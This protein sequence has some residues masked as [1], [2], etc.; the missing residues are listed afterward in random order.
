MGKYLALPFNGNVNNT[1]SL[2]L[3]VITNIFVKLAIA[4]NEYLLNKLFILFKFFLIKLD[5]LTLLFVGDDDTIN[6]STKVSENFSNF[7]GSISHT[8]PRLPENKQTESAPRT[9]ITRLNS[10]IN[11]EPPLSEKQANLESSVNFNCKIILISIL[12]FILI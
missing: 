2:G 9:P 12:L 5:E 4:N 10:S 11:T 6:L 1:V 7:N 8:S 3:K